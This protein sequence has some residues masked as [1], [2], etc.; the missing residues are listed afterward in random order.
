L[1]IQPTK[2]ILFCRVHDTKMHKPFLTA[3]RG[4]P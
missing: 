1:L 3:F 4:E 2:G